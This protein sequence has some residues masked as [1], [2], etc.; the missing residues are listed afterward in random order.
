M[1]SFGCIPA[2]L[3]VGIGPSNGPCC[4][5]VGE[6][7]REEAIAALGS[8]DG[9]ILP[10]AVGGKYIF[11]Q[12]QANKMQ[13]LNCGVKEENIE[14]TNLCSQTHHDLFFSSRAGKGVTGRTTSG[15]MLL[16]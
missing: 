16:E 7:V 5:E 10:A 12:W 6:D 8:V 15:I 11:D 1:E 2:D 3:L 13:L 9:I 4:Y 14:I